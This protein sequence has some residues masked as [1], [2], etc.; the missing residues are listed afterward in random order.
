VVKA[1]MGWL[2][3]LNYEKAAFALDFCH[4]QSPLVQLS[5]FG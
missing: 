4:S 1:G 5:A 2:L 3:E